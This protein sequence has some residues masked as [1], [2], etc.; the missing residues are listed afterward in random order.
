[1]RNLGPKRS[2]SQPC[3]GASQVCSTMSTENVIWIAGRPAPVAA[4]NGATNSVQ[5]YCGLEIDI[6][7]ISPRL[8][9]PQRFADNADTNSPACAI[10]VSFA[11]DMSASPAHGRN[12]QTQ[13]D[14]L[15]SSRMANK[16]VLRKPPLQDAM[17]GEPK[18]STGKQ[19]ARSE[20]QQ[21]QS[22]AS[23]LLSLGSNA[24][25]GLTAEIA[26]ARLNRE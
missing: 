19:G 15:S 18:M 25:S 20:V 13:P 24:Q 17:Q 3:K 16:G 5:T 26:A 2:T 11:K 8:S 23:T 22:A 9:W 12:S 6:I 21:G 7:A 10:D 1:M 14:H 4:W